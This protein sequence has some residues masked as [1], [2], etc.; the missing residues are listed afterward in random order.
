MD[1][2]LSLLNVSLN[3]HT[4][5]KE[6]LAVKDL[7]FDVSSGEF[8][9]IIGPSGCG[10]TSILS[11]IAGLI[12]GYG[13]DVFF[14]GEKLLKPS[15]KIGYMLQRDELF[16]WLT[17]SENVYLPLKIKRL[18]NKENKD[19]A[20]ELIKKYGL[21]D[22]CDFYPNQLSGGMRQRAALIRTLAASPE[23]L[24]L[25]E[26]FSALD[27]QTRLVVCNDVHGIIKSE[28]KTALLVTHDIS[29]AVSL[30]DKII[31]LTQRPAKV[32]NC[33]ILDFDKDLTPI[34][35]RESDRFSQWFETLWRDLN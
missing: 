16:P 2:L 29:E 22:F 9:A 34:E 7:S 4:K 18:Y 24:L 6:T 23:L 30:S 35:R 25:D 14:D 20:D 26:P 12:K 19:L 17:I 32:K 33:Y 31:V 8:A 3:Y 5:Q 10:K 28:N 1:S 21:I 11:L 27:Y 15:E 13:G